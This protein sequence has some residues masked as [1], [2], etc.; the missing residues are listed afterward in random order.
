MFKKASY[1]YTIYTEGSFTKAAQKLFISQPCL[2]AAIKQIEQK[3]GSALFE[4]TSGKVKPTELG[5]KYIRTA[6]QILGLEE[7]FLQQLNDT[8]TLACGTVR[9]GGSNYVATHILPR[10][11]DAFSKQY[12]KVTVSLTEASSAVLSQQLDDGSVDLIVDS[13]DVPG[14]DRVHHPLSQEQI[15]LAVP[16]ELG[17]NL[18]VK[19]QGISPTD[20]FDSK[21]DCGNLAPVPLSVFAAAPFILLKSGNS[22]YNHAMDA[23]RING[24][25]P[26]VQMFLDQLATSYYLASQGNSCCFVTDTLFRY[27]RFE[28]QVLLYRIQGSGSRSLDIAYKKGHQPTPA[29]RKFIQIAQEILS[30]H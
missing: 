21:A 9:V 25:T 2:S 14:T 6:E 17:C 18:S 7:S 20:L 4:R 22:M 30:R 11:I 23:F 13:F 28:D 3:L 10:I 1:V 5:L 24:V 29:E 16:N 26:K 12:P 8:H 19:S 15:L 27:H